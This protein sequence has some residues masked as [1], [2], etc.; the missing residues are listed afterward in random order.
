MSHIILQRCTTVAGHLPTIIDTP[1]KQAIFLDQTCLSRENHACCC[2]NTYSRDGAYPE[3]QITTTT[4]KITNEHTHDG[5]H[6]RTFTIRP[7]ILKHGPSKDHLITRTM[8]SLH[9][10]TPAFVAQRTHQDV[11]CMDVQAACHSGRAMRW[12]FRPSGLMDV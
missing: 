7:I 8:L 2:T 5:S 12:T 11:R 9:R 1:Y 3:Y 4:P 10:T 6:D